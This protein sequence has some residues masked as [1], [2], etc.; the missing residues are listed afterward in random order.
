MTAK[1][2]PLADSVGDDSA[3]DLEADLP[4]EA[5]GDHALPADR[6]ALAVA[7]RAD[8]EPLLGVVDPPDDDDVEVGS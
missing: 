4:A 7:G 8:D 1:R 2:I 3:P 6:L 5:D